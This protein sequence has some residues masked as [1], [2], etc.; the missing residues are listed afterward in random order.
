[1]HTHECNYAC[2]NLWVHAASDWSVGNRVWMLGDGDGSGVWGWSSGGWGY[3]EQSGGWRR[4]MVHKGYD[5]GMSNN[6]ELCTCF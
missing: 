2:M 3:Q 5:T 4:I 6:R 1:M